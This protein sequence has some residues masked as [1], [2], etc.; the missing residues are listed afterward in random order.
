[1]Y[2][3]VTSPQSYFRSSPAW[4]KRFADSNPN[5]V[6]AIRV[7]DSHTGNIASNSM[8][9]PSFACHFTTATLH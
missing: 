1:M 6:M 9:D 2:H 7:K 5:G 4:S 8:Q 3:P